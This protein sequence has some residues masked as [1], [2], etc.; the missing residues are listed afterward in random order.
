MAYSRRCRGTTSVQE[1]AKR[2]GSSLEGG[3]FVCERR[4]VFAVTS[5]VVLDGRARW[6][7]GHERA[8]MQDRPWSKTKSPTG[9]EVTAAWAPG[10]V[11]RRARL[12]CHGCRQA[13]TSAAWSSWTPTASRVSICS[14]VNGEE[15]FAWKRRKPRRLYTDEKFVF[16]NNIILQ[17]F[18][19]YLYLNCIINISYN[20]D[21]RPQDIFY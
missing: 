16:L 3:C 13:C 10:Y 6:G 11:T 12:R 7:K 2:S 18:Y 5:M 17:R 14:A 1:P 21:L 19:L 9:I 20:L 8:P 4:L 15:Y